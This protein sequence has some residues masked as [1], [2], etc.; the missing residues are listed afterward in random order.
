MDFLNIA[1]DEKVSML[2]KKAGS[3]K[4]YVSKS[5]GRPYKR[6]WFTV[7]VNGKDFAYG[8][9]M[10]VAE[11]INKAVAEGNQTVTIGDKTVVAG[12]KEYLTKGSG[13]IANKVG[14][15]EDRVTK[16]EKMFES[17]FGAKQ[18]A[19]AAK[20]DDDGVPF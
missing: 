5:S 9:F 3:V 8:A 7:A 12:G 14:T 10:N 19:K 16:L 13:E 17:E 20:I 6:Q 18:C 15:L 1:K 4:D 11:A 2:I